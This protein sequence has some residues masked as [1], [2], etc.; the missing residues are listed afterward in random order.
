V[1]AYNLITGFISTKSIGTQGSEITP[2]ISSSIKL[3]SALTLCSQRIYSFGTKPIIHKANLPNQRL[4]AHATV[5]GY[6]LSL[7]HF[8]PFT[9]PVE[10]CQST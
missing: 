4:T 6:L 5:P 7:N 9:N 1:E 10:I 2:M 3:W 8:S